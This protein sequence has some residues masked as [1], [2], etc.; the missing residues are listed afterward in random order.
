MTPDDVLSELIDA[1]RPKPQP[2]RPPLPSHL[3]S[4]HRVALALRADLPAALTR[5]QIHALIVEWGLLVDRPLGVPGDRAAARREARAAADVIP[6]GHPDKARAWLDAFLG[7]P[8]PNQRW[9][10]PAH[11]RVARALWCLY[12]DTPPEPGFT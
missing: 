8:Q 1:L 12:L 3:P 10:L 7:T 6:R 5:R 4:A 2:R 11:H 9:G